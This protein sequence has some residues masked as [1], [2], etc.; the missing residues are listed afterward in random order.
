MVN[1][2]NISPNGS[3]KTSDYIKVL[4]VLHLDSQVFEKVKMPLIKPHCYK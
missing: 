2:F 3:L 1:S 4:T